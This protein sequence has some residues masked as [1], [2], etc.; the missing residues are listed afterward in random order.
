MGGKHSNSQAEQGMDWGQFSAQRGITHD[1]MTV[2]TQNIAVAP[3]LADKEA[4]VLEN[5]AVQPVKLE[6]GL[7]LPSLDLIPD[8][9]KPNIFYLTGKLHSLK[10][11]KARI[12]L[13]PL[14]ETPKNPAHHRLSYVSRNRADSYSLEVELSLPAGVST[15]IPANSVKVDISNTPIDKFL[16]SGPTHIPLYIEVELTGAAPNT[17]WK[18][19][20]LCAFSRDKLKPILLQHCRIHFT[21]CA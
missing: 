10:P 11:A 9:D 15:M 2:G 3:K 5:K 1:K 20:Y 13:L 19:F 18:Q 14:I 7:E 8:P 6:F 16:N 4:P 12:V 21:Q 17:I